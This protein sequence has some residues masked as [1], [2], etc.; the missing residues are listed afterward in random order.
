ME[1]FQQ[2]PGKLLSSFEPT[3]A[4][5]KKKP[6]SLRLVRSFGW[7]FF[8][9]QTGFEKPITT[10]LTG[11]FN[12]PLPRLCKPRGAGRAPTATGAALGEHL[13]VPF[14]T[15][16]AAARSFPLQTTGPS[17][18]KSMAERRFCPWETVMPLV[19]LDT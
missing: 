19:V 7:F 16:G 3:D 5:V 8:F 12:S 9:P 17:S 14:V 15:G 10:F 2:I 11:I 4:K 1:V 13:W 18:L 6:W